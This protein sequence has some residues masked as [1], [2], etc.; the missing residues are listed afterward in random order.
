ML[1]G[2][3]ILAFALESDGNGVYLFGHPFGSACHFKE[4]HG[5][6]CG[7][8]G[9]TRAWTF[10]A[11]LNFSAAKK[12]NPNGPSTFWSYLLWA[13]ASI[14]LLE[15]YWRARARGVAVAVL[16]V[17]L[18]L[19]AF[20]YGYYPLYRTNVALMKEYEGVDMKLQMCPE[21]P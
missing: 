4:K 8:C 12:M 1:L 10:S 17:G 21:A 19:S 5:V 13:S 7:S 14:L 3:I 9:L 16:I 2:P 20:F 15:Y 18:G 11:E 6:D